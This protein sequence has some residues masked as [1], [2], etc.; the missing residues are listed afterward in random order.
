M[1]ASRQENVNMTTE[2]TQLSSYTTTDCYTVASIHS[3]IQT[4]K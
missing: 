3:F 2:P 4:F 1:S